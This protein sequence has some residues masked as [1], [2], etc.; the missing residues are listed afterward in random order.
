MQKCDKCVEKEFVQT[1]ESLREVS[2]PFLVGDPL[3]KRKQ[4][5]RNVRDRTIEESFKQ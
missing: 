2:M 4:T 3:G 1:K 5:A